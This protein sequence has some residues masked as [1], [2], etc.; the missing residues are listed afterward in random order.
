MLAK[1]AAGQTD[2]CK[3]PHVSTHRNANP[4]WIIVRK[5]PEMISYAKRPL[6]VMR[7]LSGH[8]SR[9]HVPKDAQPGDEPLETTYQF[10]LYPLWRWHLRN[11]R[12]AWGSAAS[13]WDSPMF[14]WL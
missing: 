11:G 2:L 14:L 7:R 6:A 8:L 9:Q 13:G 1:R 12:E 4:D 3:S 10:S 5:I